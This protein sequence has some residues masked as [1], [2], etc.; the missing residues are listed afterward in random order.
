MTDTIKERRK[1][2]EFTVNAMALNTIL[3]LAMSLL[4]ISIEPPLSSL[5]ILVQSSPRRIYD[6]PFDEALIHVLYVILYPI[7]THLVCIL[8]DFFSDFTY[9]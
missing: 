2:N 9:G 3:V 7:D 5:N 6:C 8:T 1:S 4:T